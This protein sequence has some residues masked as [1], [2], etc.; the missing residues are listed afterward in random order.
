MVQLAR[1]SSIVLS[2]ALGYIIHQLTIRI[3]Y[4]IHAKDD[5]P[6]L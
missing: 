3:N 1:V 2:L 5:F 4:K 6:P